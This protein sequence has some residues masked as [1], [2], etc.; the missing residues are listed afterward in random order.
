MTGIAKHCGEVHE[1]DGVYVCPVCLEL[2]NPVELTPGQQ[3]IVDRLAERLCIRPAC[4]G[5][6][7]AP[8]TIDLGPSLDDHEPAGLEATYRCWECE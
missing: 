1:A 7:G 8:L 3:V 2:V 4:C 6:C 5:Q